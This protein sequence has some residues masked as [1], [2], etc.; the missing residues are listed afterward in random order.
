MVPPART[1][2]PDRIARLAKP[3]FILEARGPQGTARRMVMPE[4]SQAGR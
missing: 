4:P 2:M 3:F 1:S